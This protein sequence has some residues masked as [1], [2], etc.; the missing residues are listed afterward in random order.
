MKRKVSESLK[1]QVAFEQEYKCSDCNGLLPP[2]YQIDH[3]LPFSISHDDSRSNLTALCPNCHAN[4][5]QKECRRILYYKKL[6]SSCDDCNICYFCLEEYGLNTE[7]S[8]NRICA[9]IILPKQ[10]PISS[11]SLYKFAF[12]S[13][14]EEDSI[15]S[16]VKRLKVSNDDRVVMYIKLTRPYLIINHHLIPLKDDLLTP[17][18]I[19]QEVRKLTENISSEQGKYTDV[20]FEVL[21][22]NEGGRGGDACIDYL[23]SLLPE[24]IPANIFK[25]GVKVRYTYFA[26]DEN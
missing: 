11:D 5:T 18:D 13:K 6:V 24:E 14:K 17:Y 19:G 15:C 1:K 9:P 21:V 7:H 25:P 22:R 4:K 8:C 23:A 10:E 16:R 20:E 26:D 2:S 12:L 3:I